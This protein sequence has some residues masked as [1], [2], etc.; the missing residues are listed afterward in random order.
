MSDGNAWYSSQPLIIYVSVHIW[1]LHTMRGL[2]LHTASYL[3]SILMCSRSKYHL[4]FRNKTKTNCA[5]SCTSE[6]VSGSHKHM[7]ATAW[8]HFQSYAKETSAQG[9]EAT[10]TE[11]LLPLGNGHF[12]VLSVNMERKRYSL[13]ICGMLVPY[14]CSITENDSL[15]AR[16]FT[17]ETNGSGIN[18]CTG[19]LLK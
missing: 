18:N 3:L 8:N 10:Q 13:D 9:Y 5:A 19:Q 4:Y 15:D 14:K 12:M 11:R 16:I 17:T 1:R 6:R 2:Q 7:S